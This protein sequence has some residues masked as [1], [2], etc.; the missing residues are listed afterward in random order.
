MGLTR[1]LTQRTGPVEY[2]TLHRP[3]VRNAFDDVMIGELAE[4]ASGLASDTSVRAVVLSG[5]GP[6][7]SAGADVSWM[8]RMAD[9][10]EEENFRDAARTS[11]MFAAIDRLPVPVIARVHGAA[12]G[13]G[14]GL[15]AVSDIVV[16]EEQAVFGFTEV[17]LGLIPAVISPFVLAKI[18]RSAA[19]ELFLTGA[20]FSAERAREIQL[21]HVVVP[22]AD[23]DSTIARYVA[24]VLASGPE[25]ITAAKALIREVSSATEASAAAAT[26]RALAIRRASRE[27]REGL[28]AFLEKRKPRWSVE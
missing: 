25:A 21:V 16:A 14:A 12:I 17:R 7:F 2:L 5:A 3:E 22:D 24:D 9:F 18:G 23:L 20:R 15:A 6:V 8:A 27:G 11:E 13:G 10:S 26:A 19:R 1:L 4:W 28:A